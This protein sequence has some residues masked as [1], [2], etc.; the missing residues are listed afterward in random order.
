MSPTAPLPHKA[1]EADFEIPETPPV[2]KRE[3]SK[4]EDSDAEEKCY[5]T[6]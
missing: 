2:G 5:S 3:V 1:Q 6:K 4:H